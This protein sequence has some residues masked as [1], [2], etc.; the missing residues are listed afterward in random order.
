MAG[1]SF[2]SGVYEVEGRSRKCSSTALHFAQR[3]SIRTFE[4][5]PVAR[6]D[7]MN[8]SPGKD[9]FK[10]VYLTSSLTGDLKIL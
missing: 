5:C 3:A 1:E 4:N 6:L 7:Y 9:H 10:E 2:L 8:F